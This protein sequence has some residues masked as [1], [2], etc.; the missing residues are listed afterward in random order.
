MTDSVQ[1]QYAQI[2]NPVLVR[3]LL[4]D[5]KWAWVW[6]PVRLYLGWIW[7][8]GGWERLNDVDWIGSGEAVRRFWSQAVTVSS[9]GE[10]PISCSWYRSF[11]QM[12]LDGGHHTWFAR[13][14][15]FTEIALGVLLFVGAFTGF[16]AALSAF[17]SWN[18][19]MAGATSANGV[20][21][22]LSL[23]LLAAWRVAGHYGLDR[24]L[25]PALGTPWDP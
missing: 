12:L 16:A 14:I 2:D 25:L 6:L 21:F 4:S 9:S 15:V 19:I 5:L 20:L 11:I 24:R 8:Q 22:L 17:M 23:A 1:D 18:F 10:S 7:F 3:R 13:L